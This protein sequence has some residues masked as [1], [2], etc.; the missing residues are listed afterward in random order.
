MGEGRYMFRDEYKE[1]I[2]EYLQGPDSTLIDLER[3]SAWLG[4]NKYELVRT[5]KSTYKADIDFIQ[6]KPVGIPKKTRKSNHLKIYKLTQDCFKH[7]CMKSNAIGAC[8]VR[9][10]LSELIQSC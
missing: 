2:K 9:K 4:V 5:L 6:G 3:V 10:Y 8:D 1:E 7:I